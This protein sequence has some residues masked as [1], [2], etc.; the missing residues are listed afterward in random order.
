M[1][2]VTSAAGKTGQAVIK[3]LHARSVAVRAWVRHEEQA[4]EIA[5]LGVAD[6]VVG[7]LLDTQALHAAIRDIQAAYLI[8]PN[9]HPEEL[10]IGQNLIAAAQANNVEHIVYHSVLHPQVE[11]MPHHWAKLR[12]EEALFASGI[13]FTILQPGAYMQNIIGK[14]TDILETLKYANPYSVNAQFSLVDLHDVAEVAA[15]VL[16]GSDHRGAIYELAGPQ[17]LNAKDI[18]KAL[19][20]A[21]K[22]TIRALEYPLDDWIKSQSSSELS[23]YEI[24][25]LS[26]MFRY[27]DQY[28]LI[29]SPNVLAWLLGRPPRTLEQCLAAHIALED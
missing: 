15:N 9:V 8:A 19:S 10:A 27:Y 26:A 11:A 3:A 16:T 22:T 18:A 25:S 23:E 29:G 1:I 17:A 14:L 13:A 6:V 21:L 20:A 4:T 12:V 5:S 28:G 7:D 24:K 2:L